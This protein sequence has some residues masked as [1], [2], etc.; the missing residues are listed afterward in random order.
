MTERQ[1][2]ANSFQE[3]TPPFPKHVPKVER[4]MLGTTVR[5]VKNRTAE[6]LPIVQNHNDEL[7]NTHP[8]STHFKPFFRAVLPMVRPGHATSRPWEFRQSTDSNN[9][10]KPPLPEN[11]EAALRTASRCTT[12][13]ETATLSA[14]HEKKSI[15]SNS[16]SGI[17]G[18]KASKFFG[19][20]SPST[21]CSALPRTCFVCLANSTAPV[22]ISATNPRSQICFFTLHLSE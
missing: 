3:N 9:R 7:F 5:C 12:P 8:G 13:A 10:N 11:N 15:P 17:S 22:A 14:T 16:L 19:P 6:I 21:K 20:L 2:E 1:R 4:G 18:G